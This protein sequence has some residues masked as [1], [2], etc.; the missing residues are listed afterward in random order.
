MKT[1]IGTSKVT[2][3]FLMAT[4]FTPAVYGQHQHA[5]HTSDSVVVAQTAVHFHEALVAGDSLKV[6]TLLMKDARILESGGMETREEYLS[7][8]FHSDSAFLKEIKRDTGISEV[9]VEGDFAWL[10][11]K[12]RM[13][14]IYKGNEIDLNSAELM[15]LRN[16]T[17]GWRIVA[18]HWSSRNR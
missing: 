8:H 16:T 4:C 17:E 10:A 5:G 3:I 7:H 2:L 11:T 6:A 13:H 14:G 15:L 18:I 1:T 12:N 9:R